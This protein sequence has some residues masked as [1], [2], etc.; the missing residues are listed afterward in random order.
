MRAHEASSSIVEKG[1]NFAPRLATTG[2]TRSPVG[3]WGMQVKLNTHTCI[4]NPNRGR[5]SRQQVQCIAYLDSYSAFVAKDSCAS[6]GQFCTYQVPPGQRLEGR[7]GGRKNQRDQD[8]DKTKESSHNT[9]MNKTFWRRSIYVF[10]RNRESGA[11]SH[12]ASLRN[13]H[14]PSTCKALASVVLR[15]LRFLCS[16][17]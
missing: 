17:Y 13:A 4:G 10:C 5:I 14:D 6:C 12:D 3:R 8:Q 1:M 16:T 2:A 9:L 7:E 11:S 15:F